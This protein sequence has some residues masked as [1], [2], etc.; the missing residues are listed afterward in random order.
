MLHTKQRRYDLDWL[1]VIAIIAVYLHHVGMPFNGDDFH[2]MNA[3]SS[4]LL[5]DIMV[6]F[7]QFRLPLL[8]LI[9]GTGTMFA[10]SKR[11]WLQFLKER[12]TRLLIPLIFGILVIVPPQ[13]YFEDIT[14]YTS[15]LDVYIQGAIGGAN[16]LW[17]IENLFIMSACLIPFILILRSARS[18]KAI[19]ALER[20]TVQRYGALLFVL[21]LIA[22]AII[23][24]QYYPS[25]SKAI[26][27][28]STTLYYGFFFIM[29][30]VFAIS[31]HM[32]EHLKTYRRFNMVAFIT[33]AVLFYVYYLIPGSYLEPYFTI[34]VRWNI[35]YLVCALV[36]WS[37]VITLLGYAQVW[38]SK[39]SAALKACNEAIYPFY[40]LHQTVLIVVG[41]YIIQL[42]LAIPLKIILLLLTSFPL[43]VVIYRYLIYPYRIPRLLF[44][45]KKRVQ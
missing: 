38:L 4:K 15:L 3:N 10:F 5:D 35:W 36:G 25:N 44:G 8:F 27:N 29:G 32:W 45:M 14:K 19:H 31:N 40:M 43:I 24:K 20:I 34:A 7:E 11:S 41:Y 9:S 26:T 30:M 17:F 23:S 22:I 6:F 16:H 28:L 2:I 18:Q 42:E 1:R 12:S 39:K 33:C 13:T 37:F 21:P